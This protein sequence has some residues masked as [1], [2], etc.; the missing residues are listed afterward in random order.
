MSTRQ[1]FV[2]ETQYEE[3]ILKQTQW[4]VKCQW[5]NL[6]PLNYDDGKLGNN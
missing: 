5:L 3:T 4:V 1:V 2:T 6:L